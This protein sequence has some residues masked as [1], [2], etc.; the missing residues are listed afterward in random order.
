MLTGG[1]QADRERGSVAVF[2]VV[3]AIAVVFLTALILDGGI[4]MNAKERAADIAEQAARAAADDIAPTA[5]RGG[6]V[7][8]SAAA[9]DTPGPATE[10]I[11]SYAKGADV[12]ASMTSCQPGTDPQ[13]APDVTVTVRL[14]MTPVISAGKFTH[15]KVV[16]TETAYLACGTADAQVAC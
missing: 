16:A 7:E 14:Y 13:G 9:C 4:A 8:I 15:V 3:F 6:Q 12:T 1:L 11:S 10:L 2:T 5:L